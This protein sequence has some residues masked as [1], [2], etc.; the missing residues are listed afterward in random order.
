MSTGQL[1]PI[2][3]SK[4]KLTKRRGG[5]AA[6]IGVSILLLIVLIASSLA[7]LWVPAQLINDPENKLTVDQRIERENQVRTNLVQLIATFAQIVGGAVLLAGLYFTWR[8]IQATETNVELALQTA[9]NNLKI[10]R[11]TLENSRTDQLADRFIK[12]VEQLGKSDEPGKANNLSFRLGGIYALEKV[13]KDSP[14][15]HWRVM[16]ILTSFVR[17]KAPMKDV[18]IVDAPR[19]LAA[20]I[21]AILDVIARRELKHETAEGLRIDLR[22]SD[23]R[24]ARL[25]QANF[26]KVI[27]TK[28]CMKGADFDRAILNGALM[29]EA[30]LSNATLGGADIRYADLNGAVLIGAGLEGAYLNGAHLEGAVLTDASLHGADLS[31]ANLSNAVGLTQDQVD[32]AKMDERTILP[33]PLVRRP[34]EESAADSHT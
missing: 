33:E 24:G 16:E 5:K 14:E 11:Q 32:A 18:C 19:V 25:G 13:A 1:S 7:Y 21:Q 12:A 8:N 30:C 27:L 34:M 10:S 31:G 9:E 3:T 6:V 29:G 28:C 26:K 4:A 23:L 15:D 2:D 22:E 20:D 17:E